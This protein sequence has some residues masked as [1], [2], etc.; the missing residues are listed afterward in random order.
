MI[1]ENTD[2]KLWQFGFACEDLQKRCFEMAEQEETSGGV[3]LTASKRVLN[4]FVALFLTDSTLK[5]IGVG[6]Y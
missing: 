3:M 2:M 6:Q 5:Q 1:T 4:A